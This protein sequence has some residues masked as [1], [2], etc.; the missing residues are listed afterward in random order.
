MEKGTYAEAWYVYRESVLSRM[1]LSP[2]ELEHHKKT[3][4]A[5]AIFSVALTSE[6]VNNNDQPGF[7]ALKFE[8]KS[9][10]GKV[11]E[12]LA[13]SVTTKH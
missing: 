3:F 5:G 1:V 13:A 6:A 2:D 11:M 12:D 10:A 9:F 4:Y 8:L 7:E